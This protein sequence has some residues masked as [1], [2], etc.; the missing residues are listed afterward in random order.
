L[1]VGRIDVER[2]RI[3]LGEYRGRA[4]PS[5]RLGGRI[6]RERGTH[7]LV[8]VA[9]PERVENEDDRIRAVRDA[10]GLPD[11][12]KGRSLAFEAL[13][14]RPEDEPPRLQRPPEGVL[15][16]RDQRCVLRADVNVRNP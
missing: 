15:E 2:D 1:D 12:E 13:D 14:L 7:D 8:A 11:A 5:D 16:L 3:D 4:A 9:D 6:E 10:E